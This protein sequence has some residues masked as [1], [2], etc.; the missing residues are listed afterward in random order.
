VEFVIK[1]FT[2]D[3]LPLTTQAL[4]VSKD[5]YSISMGTHTWAGKL[6]DKKI[7][8]TIKFN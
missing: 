2:K 8:Y 4:T 7:F 3:T 1:W 6:P 5:G